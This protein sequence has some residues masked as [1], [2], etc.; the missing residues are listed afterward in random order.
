MRRYLCLLNY[1]GGQ[2]CSVYS[3]LFCG[4]Q[5]VKFEKTRARVGAFTLVS[6]VLIKRFILKLFHVLYT[7]SVVFP[8]NLAGKE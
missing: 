4:W 3:T 5:I 7:Q 8:A 1:L 2:L 6:L